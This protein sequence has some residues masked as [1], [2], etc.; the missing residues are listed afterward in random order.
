M[1]W[2][3]R[4]P[5]Q[6]PASAAAITV[7]YLCMGLPPSNPGYRPHFAREQIVHRHAAVG[8][9]LVVGVTAKCLDRRPALLDAVGI[10]IGSVSGG[11]LVGNRRR[12]RQR[13]AGAG[14]V[15][16]AV[17]TAALGFV[18][19]LEQVHRD[20]GMPFEHR[21]PD[22]DQVHDRENAGLLEEPLLLGAMIRE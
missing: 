4:P 15:A 5:M 16:Q 6:A 18:E 14:E 10:R 8:H 20:P 17:E 19:H 7:L 12:P 1:P 11:N 13:D 21:P 3:A 22:R 9:A 2:A